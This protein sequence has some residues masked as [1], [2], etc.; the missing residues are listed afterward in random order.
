MPEWLRRGYGTCVGVEGSCPA[1]NGR[2]TVGFQHG[3]YSGNDCGFLNSAISKTHADSKRLGILKS[4][5]F[6]RL[7]IET[8]RTDVSETAWH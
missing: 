5:R 1:V 4:C 6:E 7:Q 3:T 8:V 2:A